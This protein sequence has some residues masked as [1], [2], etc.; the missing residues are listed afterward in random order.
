MVRA[1]IALRVLLE[2]ELATPAAK[3]VIDVPVTAVRPLARATMGS[4]DM[5]H[6]GSSAIAEDAG[7]GPAPP[8]WS[9]ACSSFI[10]TA[11]L[12]GRRSARRA[13]AANS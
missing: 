11:R 4:T 12:L 3:G 6:T 1:E 5:A 10:A 9:L 13:V 7:S 8:S 2:V